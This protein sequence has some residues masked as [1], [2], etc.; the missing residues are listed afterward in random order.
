MKFD[1]QD[2]AESAASTTV[3]NFLSPP[4]KFT[5]P[6]EKSKRDSRDT[7]EDNSFGSSLSESSGGESERGGQ[8]TDQ[9]LTAAEDRDGYTSAASRRTNPFFSAN[10]AEFHSAMSS[11]GEYDSEDNSL[12]SATGERRVTITKER[13]NNVLLTRIGNIFSVLF[14]NLRGAW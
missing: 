9:Y 10:E 13:M 7:D 6:T 5:L 3:Q 11:A 2:D 12:A 1:D 4:V 14:L 8:T